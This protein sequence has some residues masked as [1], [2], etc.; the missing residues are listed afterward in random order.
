MD[1]DMGDRALVTK[2][3]RRLGFGLA[4]G[5]LDA[6]LA[7]GVAAEVD[8]LTDP[9][10]TGVP[11]APDPWRDGELGFE[12][13]ENVARVNTAIAGWLDRMLTTPRPGEERL[14]W[15]WHGHFVSSAGKVR[16]AL[17][18]VNQIRTFQRLGTGAFDRLVR[19]VTVDPAMLDYLDGRTSTAKATNENYSR[20]LLE[21]FTLGRGNYTEADVANGAKA[22]TGWTV[23]IADGNAASFVK[24]RH[25]PTVRAYLGATASDVDSVVARVVAHPALPGFV[26]GEWCRAVLGPEVEQAA[27]DRVAEA[28]RASGLEGRT[29]V[30][31]VAAELLAGTDGGP[32]VLEPVRWLVAAQRATGA[33]LAP[34]VRLGLLRSMGQIP[35]RPP[36]VSGWPDGDAWLDTAV[37]VGRFNAAVALAGATPRT[38]AALQAADADALARALGLPGS[39]GELTRRQLER[40]A[41]AAERLTLALASPEFLLA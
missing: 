11:A 14:V 24:A 20:E 13:S 33:T 1:R 19:A 10:R 18:M 30:R 8:R 4:A 22:L 3:H 27:V 38:S 36:N 25:D 29:L 7:R 26:A 34:A 6:A 41:G 32:I 15:F 5:Q 21:L 35:L 31:A 9:D 23:T 16:A 40:S 12:R 17:T 37:V 28:Y 39:F 2:L